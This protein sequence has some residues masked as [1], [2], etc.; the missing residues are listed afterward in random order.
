MIFLTGFM[1]SGK[2]SVGRRLA[3]R[4][5]RP[6]IDIDDEVCA[7]T[8][9]TVRDIF[10]CAG[11]AAFRVL[12]RRALREAALRGAG[13]VVATGGGLPVD[14]SNRAVMKACGYVVHLSAGFET[15]AGRVPADAS[16]PLWDDGAQALLAE[17][18][19]AYEDADVTVRTDGLSIL[20]TTEAVARH[21]EAL[22]TPVPVLTPSSPYPVFIGRGIFGDVRR[23]VLRHTRPEGLFLVVDEQVMAHHGPLVRSALPACRHAVATVPPGESSKSFDV[24]KGILD[25]M[26]AARVN[27][28][29]VCLAVGGG[30][31]GDL[32]AFAA[33]IFMRGIPVVQVPTTLLAQVDSSIGG[34]TGID[35]GQ[36]KNLV[37]T[38]HQPLL[39]LSDAAFLDTLDPVQVKDAM[40]EVVKYGIIMDPG[41]FE[42]LETAGTLDLETVVG[43]CA[44]DKALVVGRDEREGGLRRILNFGHTLG[45]AIEQAHG[46]GLSH[47]RAV[48]AG[49]YF[50]AWLSREMGLTDARDTE[51]IFRVARKWSY[52][53]EELPYPHQDR[54]NGALAMDKKASGPGIDFVLTTGIGGVTV[55][56]LTSSQILGAYGRFV[57]ESAEGL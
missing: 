18:T 53:R 13:A 40:S 57:R 11:E 23:L 5:G 52:P 46:Y 14:P 24:L 39:V 28:G 3:E 30:V 55:K 22:R 37:G 2:T 25:K 6:F 9:K 4:L 16:R 17:R 35:V 20:E 36:G 1:G 34:K 19:P 12:E 33:S 29:W 42:Y 56:N 10:S 43:M 15:L 44:R 26:F 48:C 51:R 47:G 41:L 8:G 31:T 45:H 27:R 50:A 49:T 54:I 32:A 7:G 21:V 38:F